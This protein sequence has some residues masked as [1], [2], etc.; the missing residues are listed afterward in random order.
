[1][2]GYYTLSTCDPPSGLY[3]PPTPLLQRALAIVH[4]VVC[5]FTPQFSLMFN[6][7]V[8]I[9][10]RMAELEGWLYVTHRPQAVIM[11]PS[12][13]VCH[14]VRLSVPCFQFSQNRKAIETFNL[15]TL[16]LTL[17]FIPYLRLSSLI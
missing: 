14:Y 9:C 6:A 17:S 12:V 4:G 8:Y 10:G 3:A 11:T 16:T 1:M 2:D 7:F 15:V 5:L 13:S